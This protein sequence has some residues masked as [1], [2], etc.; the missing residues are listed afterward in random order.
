MGTFKRGTIWW[1]EFSFRGARI[2]ETSKSKVREVAN[3]LER[4]RRRGLELGTGGLKKLSGPLSVSHAVM[5]LMELRAPSWAERTLESH[6]S[7]WKH[8]EPFFGKMLLSDIQPKH[9][10]RYQLKRQKQ[11]AS[12]RTINIEIELLRLVMIHHRLWLNISPDV[13][14]LPEREDVGRALTPDEELRILAAAKK[15]A[16]RSLYPAVLLSL[17]TGLR[18]EELRLLQWRLADSLREQLTVGKS[19]TSGGSGRVIP[20]SQTALDCL[21]EW[22]SLFPDVKPEHYVFP[23][24]K[25]HLVGERG[26]YGGT[27]KVYNCNPAKPIR[28]WKTAWTTCRKIAEVSCRW[29]D[30]RHTFVSRMGENKVSDQTLKAMTGHLSQKMLERYSHA[31]ME[32][33]RA[34]VRTLDSGTEDKC[35]PPKSPTIGKE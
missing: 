1:Y 13:H 30:L 22:R 23:T 10:S 5:A 16:S 18:N 14:M 11:G 15:S 17:H 2:R 9:I 4:E 27:V 33:K 31:R 29:H 3:R 19:K 21:N 35:F 8:L 32:S 34:A 20:F 28:T 25:Y 26:T 7:S 24:E 6:E 12:G